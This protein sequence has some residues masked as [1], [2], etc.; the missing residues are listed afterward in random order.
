MT[1]VE[2]GVS[3]VLAQDFV[4]SEKAATFTLKAGTYVTAFEDSKALYLLGGA[5]CLE[6]HV[7]PP[8]QPEYAYT[9][10]FNCGIYYPK[11]EQGQALFFY[12]R[13]ALPR[14][15]FGLIV[16]AIIKAGEGSFNYPISKK[17]VV[18]LRSRLQAAPVGG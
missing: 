8:K 13:E 9:K 1:V 12:I 11:A 2:Q 6:M 17:H 15:E 4:A 16:N 18:G 3:Y 5:N 10:P 14:S 7:V